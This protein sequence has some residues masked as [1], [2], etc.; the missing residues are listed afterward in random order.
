MGIDWLADLHS[1]PGAITCVDTP[2]HPA[3]GTSS[4]SFSITAPAPAGTFNVYFIAYVDDSCGGVNGANTPS[5]TFV[6]T[7]GVT[8][9]VDNTTPAGSVSIN[10]GAAAT[11]STS[12]MLNLSATDAVDVT[13]YR[14]ANG[15]NCSAASYV[16]VTSTT[17]FSANVAHL[18]LA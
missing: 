10:S 18:T 7:N 17:S 4:E 8:V 2:D 16:A 14:V 15:S 6:L 9:V 12:V 1:P 5:N 13:A 3:A 11:N